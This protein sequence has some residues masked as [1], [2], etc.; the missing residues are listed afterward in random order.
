V[1]PLIQAG[2]QEA[3]QYIGTMNAGDVASNSEWRHVQLI[4]QPVG[5]QTTADRAVTT[6]D[7]V[8]VTNGAIDNSW[9]DQ[10]YSD[11]Q[12]SLSTLA[13]LWLPH[14]TTSYQLVETRYYRRAFN[15]M[16]IDKPFQFSGPPERTFPINLPGTGGTGGTVRQVALTSTDRTTYPRHWGR[17]YWPFPGSGLTTALGYVPNAT[18]DSWALAVHD[19]YAALMAKEF[20]PV[21]PVTQVQKVPTRGLLGVTAVQVDNLPDVMRSR[22]PKFTTYRALQPVS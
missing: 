11:V 9:T 17:N 16:T 19:T 10:D 2:L 6:W 5:N 12:T 3:L 13:Q 15:P 22:R 18:C 14:M 8:N 21:V 4:V 1:L 7:I 20:F